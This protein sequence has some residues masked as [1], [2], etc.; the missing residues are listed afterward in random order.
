[1]LFLEQA[2]TVTSDPAEQ[3]ELLEQSADAARIAGH[4]EQAEPLLQKA[5][6]LARQEGDRVATARAT[7]TLGYV[8]GLEFKLKEA[9]ALLE[10]AAVEFADVDE[11]VLAEINLNIGRA[12]HFSADFRG[13]LAVLEGVLEVAERRGMV[14]TVARALI[15]KGNDLASIGRRREGLGITKLA[16]DLAAEHGLTDVL[17]RSMGNIAAATGEF[18]L[19]ESAAMYREALALARR[20]GHRDQVIGSVGN[21]GYTAFLVGDW[22]ASLAEMDSFLAEDIPARERLIML[23]NALIIRTSRG[24]LI[25]DGL[26]EMERLGAVMSGEWHLFLSDPLANNEMSQGDLKKASTAFVEIADS[27]P[28]QGPEYVYRAA[29]AEIWAR[30]AAAT[31]MLLE[32]WEDLG[33]VGPVVE[34]R[35]NAIRAGIAALEGRSAEALISYREA[36]RGFRATSALWDE[37]LTGVEMAMLLDPSEPDVAAEIT[38]ARAILERLGAKPYLERLDAAVAAAPSTAAKPRVRDE[39]RAEVAVTD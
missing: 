31:R 18:S 20:T 13:S 22:D 29:R 17:L 32:T 28:G 21:Y 37:A 39:S 38:S 30:D 11:A 7:A 25:A 27:D 5:I 10:P 34:A 26:A 6:E 12:R 1:M 35:G 19:S 8:L 15:T 9:L 4:L 3:V 24:E 2:L 14:R 36:L 33:G 23:N 16:R